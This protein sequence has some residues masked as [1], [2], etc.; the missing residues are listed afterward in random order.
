VKLYDFSVYAKRREA[1][2]EA[3]RIEALKHNLNDP[4]VMDTFKQHVN[5]YLVLHAD[6][7][8]RAS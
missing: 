1:Q 4:G 8:Q 3:E 6:V 2:R 7:L 5:D